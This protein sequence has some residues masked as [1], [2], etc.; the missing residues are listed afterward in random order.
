MNL[1]VDIDSLMTSNPITVF[2]TT[3][4]TEVA[5]LFESKKIHHIP[6]VSEDLEPLG[7]ISHRDYCQLQHHFS[8][9]GSKIAKEYNDRFFS[10]LTAKDVMTPN[11]IT[12]NK[13]D[14]LEMALDLFLE[15]KFQSIVIVDEGRCIGIVS[16]HDLLTHFKECIQKNE[17]DN[18]FN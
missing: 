2:K 8:R 12:L 14:K 7:M 6:V 18:A 1:N 11:P 16:T 3:I 5:L 4:M 17:T 15:N 9:L 13:T 10:S